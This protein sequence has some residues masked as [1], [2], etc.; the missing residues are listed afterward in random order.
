MIK[1]FNKQKNVIARTFSPKLIQA[2]NVKIFF[3][4]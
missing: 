3:Y 1:I 4:R 2:F